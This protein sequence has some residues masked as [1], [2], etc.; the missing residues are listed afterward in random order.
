MIDQPKINETP[1]QH[2][3]CIR[4]KVALGEMQQAFGPVIEELVA[5]LT[6]QGMPPAGAAFAHHFRIDCQDG[7][8]SGLISRWVSP[9]TSRRLPPAG[10]MRAAGRRRKW[11][12][13]LITARMRDCPG[14]GVSSTIG[15]QPTISSKPRIFGNTTSAARSQARTYLSGAPNF[16]AHYYE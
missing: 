7:V 8:P 11:R 1:E 3:A 4:L 13:R 5:T 14:R 15:W 10:F 6:K 12:T 16:I 9:R 2:T